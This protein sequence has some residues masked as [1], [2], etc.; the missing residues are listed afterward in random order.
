VRKN[1]KGIMVVHF[2]AWIGERGENANTPGEVVSV[3]APSLTP[4][5]LI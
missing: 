2:V 1:T 5:K 3:E 4:K